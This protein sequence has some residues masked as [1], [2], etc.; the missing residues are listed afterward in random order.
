MSIAEYLPL[1]EDKIQGKVVV[2]LMQVG[3]TLLY[4]KEIGMD[5]LE[6]IVG[7]VRLI[8][9]WMRWPRK[10]QKKSSS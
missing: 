1:L 10:E 6:I 4:V 5:K 7:E 8:R 9:V 2:L 3:V